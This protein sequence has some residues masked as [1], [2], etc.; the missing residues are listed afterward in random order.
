MGFENLTDVHTRWYAQRVQHDVDRRAMHVVRHVF[1]RHDHR[2]DTLVTVTTGHLV[3]RL[4]TPLDRQVDLDDLQHARGQIVA[5][6]QLALLVFELVVEQL[7]AV[8][9][10]GLGLFQLLVQCVFGHAQLEPLPMLEPIEHL[11]SDDGAFLQPGTTLGGRANKSGA[12]TFKSCTFNDTELFIQIL[13]NLVQLHLLD[14]QRTG[15]TLDTITDEDLYV[16]DGTL[17]ASRHA[18]GGV[19]HVGRLLTEDRT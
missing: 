19:L 17:G 11:V 18:Q 15:V 5:L 12:Q 9:N 2:D 1:D 3:A 8:G 6:L 16:D 4:D 13:T 10:V 14:G 7:T